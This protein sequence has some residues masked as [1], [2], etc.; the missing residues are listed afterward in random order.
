MSEF[1]NP[2]EGIEHDAL[3]Q[4][5]YAFLTPPPPPPPPIPPPPKQKHRR[6]LVALI[7]ILCVSVILGG[8]LFMMTH[9][10][11]QSQLKAKQIVPLH[12]STPTSVATLVP[13]ATPTSL[14]T[15]TPTMN[16]SYTA[17]TLMQNINAAGIHPKFVEYNRT[18]WSWTGD[19]YSVSTHSTSSVDFTDDSSCTGNCS[20]ANLGIWVYSDAATAQE[21]YAEVANDTNQVQLTPPTAPTIFNGTEYVHGRCLLL[22]S[23][24]ASIYG[25]IVTQYCV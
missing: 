3:T 2:Y 8:V 20:P 13:T 22:G 1:P 14:P 6:F 21:A 9:V 25:Q 23:S 5:D 15:L 18:I 4:P 12:N 17:V 11:N 10:G 7:G 19:T 24:Q 16:P